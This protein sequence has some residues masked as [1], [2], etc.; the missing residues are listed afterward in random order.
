[1]PKRVPFLSGVAMPKSG[2]FRPQAQNQAVVPLQAK[3]K[4]GLALH[5]QGKLAEAERIYGEVLRHQ[6]NHFD[7]LHLLGVIARQTRRTER[8]VELISKAIRLNGKV[9]AAHSN[10]GNALN[11]LKRPADALVSYDKAIALKPDFAEAYNNRGAVLR[12]LKRPADALVSLDKAIALKPD[13]AEAYYNRGNALNDLKRSADALVSYDKAIALKPDLAEAYNNR[14]TALNDLKRPADALVSYDKAIA[15]KPD[16]VEAYNNRGN[17]LRD[18]KRPADALVSYDKAIA[19]KPD[20]AEAYNNRGTALIDQGDL[21]SAIESYKRAIQIKPDY[22]ECYWNYSAITKINRDDPLIPI[23]KK[24]ICA[25]GLSEKDL[26]HLSFALGKSE[27]DL[28]NKEPAI[29]HLIRGNAIRK[30]ELAYDISQDEQLF[31]SIKQFFNSDAT[32]KQADVVSGFSTRPIF[33][34][35]MPRSGTTLAEQIVASHSNVFGAGELEFLDQAISNSRWRVEKDRQQVFSSVRAFYN[36]QISEVSDASIITD[37]MPLNF[38]W[39]G[40]IANALPDAKIVHL[41]RDSAAVCWSIF[42]TYFGATGL[43]FAFDIQDIAKYYRLYE[44]LMDFW[45]Q[46]YPGKIYDLNYEK[47]TEN[48]NAETRKLFDYLDLGWEDN[49]LDFY[50]NKRIVRTASN[51]QVRREMYKGSSLEWKTYAQWLQPMLEILN[52]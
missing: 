20:F 33:I 19:L 40:F 8:A 28:G 7:A 11:D 37:K 21:K 2:A 48:Q 35:G 6:P 34:L 39:I 49:V 44:D 22:A 41:K 3:I 31:V 16:Y 25:E 29:N 14:G 9:A 13:L 42:K 27:L 1:M 10:L 23:M 26:M 15:L 12:D 24:L 38:R 18:L 30:K 5:Q 47:L 36:Q 45:H 46:K 50:K 17:V 51:I 52:A 32:N 43:G 4:Q